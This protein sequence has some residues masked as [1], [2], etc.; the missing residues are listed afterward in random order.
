MKKLMIAL[1]AVL[2]LLLP[3]LLLGQV[4]DAVLIDRYDSLVILDDWM[5]DTGLSSEHSYEDCS[6]DAWM[7]GED[8]EPE[9]V[10]LKDWMLKREEAE[11]EAQLRFWMMNGLERKAK[12]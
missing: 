12:R 3:T 1:F 7:L 9:V 2:T 4:D 5:L 11:E 6:V 10:D 8:E